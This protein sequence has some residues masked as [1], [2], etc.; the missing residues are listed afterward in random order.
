M[1]S[2]T[3]D[4]ISMPPI[5]IRGVAYNQGGTIAIDGTGGSLLLAFVTPITTSAVEFDSKQFSKWTEG[6]KL[7]VWKLND[8]AQGGHNVIATGA[9]ALTVVLVLGG[10]KIAQSCFWT[11]IGPNHLDGVA[12]LVVSAAYANNKDVAVDPGPTQAGQTLI[13]QAHY[14]N[15]GIA[16]SYHTGSGTVT[17][18]FNS[19]GGV[20]WIEMVMCEIGLQ[21]GGGIVF[22]G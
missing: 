16:S 3:F 11:N 9:D 19:S 15:Y 1:R 20:N 8:V 21:A 7:S 2:T 10:N 4:N 22:L 5:C 13:A 12:G 6:T 17:D 14:G 18:G